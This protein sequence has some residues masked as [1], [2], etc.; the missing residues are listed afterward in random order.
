MSTIGQQ[1]RHFRERRGLSQKGLGELIGHSENWVYKVQH[2]Q[3][4]IAKH[5]LFF[6]L[7]RV[8]SCSLDGF[9]SGVGTGPYSSK[10]SRPRVSPCPLSREA[11]WRSAPTRTSGCLGGSR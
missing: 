4:P 7:A 8:L 9:L 10:A 5:S 3:I 11:P 1:V 2:E 6:D